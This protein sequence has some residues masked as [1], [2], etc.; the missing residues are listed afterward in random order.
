MFN[1]KIISNESGYTRDLGSA[2]FDLKS[3]IDVMAVSF[4]A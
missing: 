3:D 2:R 1:Q 4:K